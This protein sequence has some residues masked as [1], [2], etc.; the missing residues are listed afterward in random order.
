MRDLAYKIAMMLSNSMHQSGEK[1]KMVDYIDQMK[2][3]YLIKTISRG[4]DENK[5]L[6]HLSLVITWQIKN[7]KSEAF[8]VLTEQYDKYIQSLDKLN[9]DELMKKLRLI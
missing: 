3:H 7:H 2:H 8:R 5:M 6:H 9:Q 1:K 4:F